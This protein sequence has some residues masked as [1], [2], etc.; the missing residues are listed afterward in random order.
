MDGIDIYKQR[1]AYSTFILGVFTMD[2]TFW[3]RT[4]NRGLKQILF[5]FLFTSTSKWFNEGN[6]PW[7][8]TAQLYNYNW[9][10]GN[11]GQKT[12]GRHEH[13]MGI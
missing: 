5:F 8:I 6:Q 2:Q 11:E 9:N 10:K 3:F 1:A 7:A 13:N 12:K 4:E